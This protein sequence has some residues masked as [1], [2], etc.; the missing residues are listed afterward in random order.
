MFELP[1]YITLAN[2]INT[3]IKGKQISEGVLG[4]SPHKFV[5]YNQTPESFAIITAGKMIGNASARGRW[6][7]V[8]LEPGY[9]LVFGECGGKILFHDI[10]DTIPAKYHLLIR[11]S[12][13]TALSALTQMWGAMELYKQGEEQK[14]QYICDMKATPTDKEFTLCWFRRLITESARGGKR[15]VKALLTQ[16]QLIPG[17]GNAIAQDIMLAARLHPKKDISELKDSQQ[18][19]LHTA[20]TGIVREVTEKG[21]RN[22]EYDLYG[23]KG[24]YVRLLDNNSLKTGCPI[25]GGTINKMQYL[26]GAAYYCSECQKL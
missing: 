7:F 12:D 11:F 24:G 16:D 26:G 25:C 10:K 3:S 23:R 6:L 5:W 9:V 14:R 1:E 21:G 2:Q 22:D 13:G 17:L 20:I 8:P 19:A 4:N 18:E 15:S